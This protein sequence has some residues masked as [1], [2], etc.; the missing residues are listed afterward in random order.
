MSGTSVTSSPQ[1][2]PVLPKDLV[3]IDTL[4]YLGFDEETA[5]FIWA[6]RIKELV[7]AHATKPDGNLSTAFMSQ[8]VEHVYDFGHVSNTCD[9]NLRLWHQCLNHCGL[10]RQT[11]AAI[12]DPVFKK[13]RLTQTCLH[14]VRNTIELRFKALQDLRAADAA[15]SVPLK[16]GQA[17]KSASKDAVPRPSQPEETAMSEAILRA[18]ESPLDTTV[19]L[20]KGVDRASVRHL[21]DDRRDL[22]R[23]S[24][25]ATFPPGN[26]RGSS[27]AYYLY[28]DR[29]IA[30][31]QACYI[32]RR[33]SLTP[34]VLVQVRI[35]KSA[36]EAAYEGPQRQELYWPSED[37]KRLAFYCRG[38]RPVPPDLVK[39]MEARLS[40]V[41]AVAKAD[42]AF[43]RNM[44]RLD[45][46][47]AD[48]V[49]KNKHGKDAIQYC[50]RRHDA[51]YFLTQH[52]ELKMLPF[53]ED[54]F[55]EWC[56]D[57]RE[58]E[59]KDI[60]ELPCRVVSG[61]FNVEG[62]MENADEHDGLVI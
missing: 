29:D 15:A 7:R 52:A 12:M 31:Q 36:L 61:G 25:L 13:I 62:A 40:I 14:W 43:T 57:A 51:D 28:V 54:E 16:R 44:N 53:T 24:A 27:S 8:V 58:E 6:D 59:L 22:S 46:I 18:S 55:Q 50:F 56:V 48:M 32:R 20:Y 47:T 17:D 26:A 38:N 35:Q 1:Q 11:K 37:W 45:Q 33:S 4:E 9:D 5:E 3:S 49:L 2:L 19:T 21:F 34:V 42:R 41:T 60:P 10:D 39:Y 30:E 23:I